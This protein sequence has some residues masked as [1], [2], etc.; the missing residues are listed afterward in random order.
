VLR[1]EV[2]IDGQSLGMTKLN[3]YN[4]VYT[5][6]NLGGVATGGEVSPWI[7][8]VWGCKAAQASG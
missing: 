7:V 6:M 1:H 2:V 5:I 3:A 4:G 8:T